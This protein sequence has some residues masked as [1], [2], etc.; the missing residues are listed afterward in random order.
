MCKAPIIWL[1]N[2]RFNLFD[3]YFAQAYKYRNTNLA[4]MTAKLAE[5]RG[6]AR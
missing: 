2:K 5:K 1:L 6:L 4:K 3:A